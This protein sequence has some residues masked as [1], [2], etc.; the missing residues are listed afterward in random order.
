[1]IKDFETKQSPIN[2]FQQVFP[3]VT[4]AFSKEQFDNVI[5]SYYTSH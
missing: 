1:M 3:E 5:N 4:S 2:L